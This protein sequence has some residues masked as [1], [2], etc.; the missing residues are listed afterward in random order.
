M[1]ALAV[2]LPILSPEQQAY[3]DAET[4][5]PF[6]LGITVTFHVLALIAVCLRLYVRTFM[7]KV[8]GPDDYTIIA[9]MICAIGGMITI[10]IEATLGLGR[11]QD[12]ISKDDLQQ[13]HMANFFF[14]LISGILGLN[15]VKISVSFLLMRFVHHRWSRICLWAVIIFMSIYTIVSW[16]TVIFLCQPISAFWDIDVLKLPSTKCYPLVVFNTLGLLNTGITIFTDLLLAT[17]PIPILWA[18]QINPRQKV[19]LI[20]VLSLGYAAVAVGIVKTSYQI[21]FLRNPDQTYDQG[22]QTWGFVQLNISI[23]AA[24]MP[25]LKPLF[26]F[27]ADTITIHIRT[28]SKVAPDTGYFRQTGSRYT[29]ICRDGRGQKEY[30]QNRLDMGSYLTADALLNP[31]SVGTNTTLVTTANKKNS[32]IS[33]FAQESQESILPI[34]GTNGIVMTTVYTV[35]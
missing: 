27:L 13:F 30:D 34:Q 31:D 22:I 4:H 20:G 7:V 25:T 32:L 10:G 23:I 19:A 12:L 21:P 8:M 17:I 5:L 9:A 18:L 14:A 16:G 2:G 15:M 26:R 3:R 35:T 1:P 29:G 24:C 11:H 33:R 6:I 28:G